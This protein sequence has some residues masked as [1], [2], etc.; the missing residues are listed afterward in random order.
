M[1]NNFFDVVIIGGGFSGVI[2]AIILKEN[3]VDCL[4]IEKND[5]LCK[6]IPS[7]GNGRGNITNTSIS[8]ENYHGDKVFASY[9]LNCYDN[10][11]LIN[12][13]EELGL[14]TIR[15]ENKVYPAS[16]QASSIS[17]LMRF[18]LDYLKCPVL[19]CYNVGSIKH[20]NGKYIINEEISCNKLVI[21]CGGKSMK[22]FGSDGSL[23]TQITNLGHKFTQLSPSLV[24]LKTETS[25]IKGLKGIKQN[26]KLTLF[27]NKQYIVDFVGDLLF[28]D[29]GISG[30]AV[31]KLSAYLG[32]VKNPN[33]KIGF[34]TEYSLED[35][36]SFLKKKAKLPYITNS[37]LLV[38]V[39]HN[40][41]GSVLVKNAKLNP[42]DKA[43]VISAQK[44]AYILK[45]LS[46]KVLGTLD[47]D[48][49]QVTH[50]GIDTSEI[51]NKTMQS[52]LVPNLYF[53]GEVLNVDGD[54]GGY[55]LQWAYS[56]ACVCARGICDNYKR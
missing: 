50:G 8:I 6:K 49:S 10:S 21:S 41:L 36:T 34:L 14:I 52:K 43:D 3:N 55:N 44:L 5:R 54:C 31:F 39:V 33:I 38:G 13:F 4:L 51:D 42:D 53:T 15:E 11:S 46:L 22:N 12:F 32:D 27:D 7:T 37:Q 19:K 40:K 28:T 23:Y 9:P 25:Q 17:D 56:S 2:T 48:S 29:Y 20:K 26:A 24:Q 35:L 18:K 45:N 1:E 16:L 30:D 47:F